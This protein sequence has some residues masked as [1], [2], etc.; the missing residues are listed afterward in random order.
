MKDSRGALV[1]SFA[2]G[3]ACGPGKST[4]ECDLASGTLPAVGSPC[5]P[6]GQNCSDSEDPCGLVLEC[7]AGTWQE[8]VNDEPACQTTET[9]TTFSDDTGVTTTGTS[10]TG[11]PTTT[12]PTTTAT[13]DA[14]TG[15]ADCDPLPEE[16][17]PC[18][19]E[20][21]F[22]SA[23][24]EDPCQFCN[25]RQCTGGVWQN[26][27]APPAQCLDCAEV[28]EFVVPAMCAGGP[29]DEPTCVSG[30][31]DSLASECELLFKQM[32]ACIG[33]AP[34]FTCDAATRP[35]VVGCDAQFTALYECMGL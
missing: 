3:L 12:S 30:C 19:T 33:P 28:C 10:T 9:P 8:R 25:V 4:Q 23:G 6:D 11:E 20:G 15:A 31:M 21:E 27:E 24:C 26:L 7:E 1:L 16:G 2:L 22:C 14:T 18:A 13:T 17:S 32:L 35:T 5:S 29:P 34:A